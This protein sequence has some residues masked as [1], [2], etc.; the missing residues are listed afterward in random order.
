MTHAS[1]DSRV[2]QLLTYAG[3]LPLIGC[4]L[5]AWVPSLA[6]GTVSAPAW[7]TTT[8]A[9]AYAA[10]IASFIAG[11]HWAA[12]LFFAERCGRLPMIASNVAALF[13]WSTLLLGDARLGCLL[14]VPCFASLLAV[15]HGLYS[16]GVL[17]P[18]FFRLRRNA[19]L[20][21]ASALLLVSFAPR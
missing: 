9:L 10:V 21:V 19:T 11:I 5:L 8:I 12:S 13:A 14:L 16:K 4:A 7:S 17:P 3:T 1:P 2:A 6:D 18:W 20:I 15:D